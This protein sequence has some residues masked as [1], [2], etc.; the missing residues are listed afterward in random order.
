MKRSLGTLSNSSQDK[1]Y[2]GISYKSFESKTAKL[3]PPPKKTEHF[4]KIFLSSTISKSPQNLPIIYISKLFQ[5]AELYIPVLH[6]QKR[7]SCCLLFLLC[8][9]CFLNKLSNRYHKISASVG[10]YCWVS[11]TFATSIISLKSTA[12]IPSREILGDGKN[13]PKYRYPL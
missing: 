13:I 5:Y 12:G 10:R 3:G 2:W 4:L 7:M 8:N 1:F 9:N 6:V 11:F